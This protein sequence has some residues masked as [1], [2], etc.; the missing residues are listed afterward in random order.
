MGLLDGYFD[1]VTLFLIASQLKLNKLG[2]MCIQRDTY[3]FHPLVR[4][5]SVIVAPWVD[6]AALEK[7]GNIT[8]KSLK[9]GVVRRLSADYLYALG[10]AEGA[11]GTDGADRKARF[12]VAL[13]EATKDV[14][15]ESAGGSMQVIW[16]DL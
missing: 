14:E 3:N 11:G 6:V 12:M 8:M 15:S 4:L 16:A 13:A 9:I 7:K 10:R 5:Q 2:G 1:V